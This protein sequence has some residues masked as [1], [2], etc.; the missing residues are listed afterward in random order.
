MD[1]KQKV[2]ML[3]DIFSAYLLNH[4]EKTFCRDTTTVLNAF[5]QKDF[6]INIID[7]S[8]ENESFFGMRIFPSD[9]YMIELCTQI[10]SGKEAPSISSMIKRWKNIKSWV[11]E[12][13][14]R[15]FDRMIINF[16]PSELTAMLLHEIGHT[17]YSDRKMEMFARV[18]RECN[19]RMKMADKAAVKMLYFLYQIPLTVLCGFRNWEVTSIDLKEEIFADM[20][21]QKLGYGE[22]LISAFEKIIKKCG[23][24]TGYSSKMED[25]V[26]QSITWCN[27]NVA[28]LEK[29]QQKIKDE[30]YLTG[31]RTNSSF[32]RNII[33]GIMDKLHIRKKE[34]YT[35]NIVM[36]SNISI[37]FSD[38][39]FYNNNE[40][41]YDFGKINKLKNSI[42]VAKES[43]NNSIAQ[44]ALFGNKKNK[45]NE[46]PSQLDVDTIFVEIDRMENHADRRYV[47]DLIYHQEEKIENFKERFAYDKELKQKHAR[48]MENMLSELESMRRTVLAKRNFDRDYKVF[49]RYPAGYEG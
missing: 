21:V 3:D 22:H 6:V 20:S 32:V 48:H 43:V 1:V 39:M 30:L 31:K 15:V 46:I 33:K 5:S 28:D 19:V 45:K 16:N 40:L 24:S 38:S 17:V 4:N 37:D 27:L 2:S 18:Y 35:G 36:E 7:E 9:D 25:S 34:R 47:L 11:I 42:R 8:D 23:N 26:E 10:T 13:D 14:S 29:R 49:V 41:V 12:I 44:E